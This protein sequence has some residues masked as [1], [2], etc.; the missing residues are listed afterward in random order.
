MKNSRLSSNGSKMRPFTLIELLVVI[1]IIAILA[2]I[3]LPALNSARERGRAA[4]CIN[5]LKQHGTAHAMYRDDSDG[6]FAPQSS[7]IIE[8]NADSGSITYSWVS[9]LYNGGYL[10]DVNCYYCP[11]MDGFPLEAGAPTNYYRGPYSL[12]N[13]STPEDVL[14]GDM[15]KSVSYGYNG[16]FV[17]SHL[18]GV[19]PAN[20]KPWKD[21]QIKTTVMLSMDNAVWNSSGNYYS[22]NY[23]AFRNFSVPSDVHKG[24]NMLWTDGHVSVESGF[25]TKLT[26]D[27]AGKGVAATDTATRDRYIKA[28]LL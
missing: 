27:P 18:Y 6:Y 5:N 15:Q 28:H 13:H 10:K 19:T 1:A 26:G 2:A 7:Q 12:R 22:I 8:N 16:Y 20:G 23:H 25:N 17:G 21:S 3:L 9:L 4:S 11:S 24:V 14:K